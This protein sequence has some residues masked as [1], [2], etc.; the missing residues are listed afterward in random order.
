MLGLFLCVLGR[1]GSF[2]KVFH[3]S[4]VFF[5]HFVLH[6]CLSSGLDVM[7]VEGGFS[8][9]ES[10]SVFCCLPFSD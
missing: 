7:T 4:K 10:L 2:I 9:T 3:Q 5:I 6:V 1:K 8:L